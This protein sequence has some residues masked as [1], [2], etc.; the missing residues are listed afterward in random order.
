M[1]LVPE[2]MAG[3]LLALISGSLILLLLWGLT[4]RCPYCKGKASTFDH[5]T[6]KFRC[7]KCKRE[8]E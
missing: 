5:D 4:V 6:G 7:H 1:V 8:F 2:G 3:I